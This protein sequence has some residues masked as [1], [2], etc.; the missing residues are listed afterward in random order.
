MVEII[1][2]SIPLRIPLEENCP[3]LLAQ[4]P[5]QLR[6]KRFL[7]QVADPDQKWAMVKPILEMAAS[8]E[9]RFDRTKFVAF[10]EASIPFRYKDEIL[11][12]IQDRFFPNTVAILG[13]EHVLF[14]QY[15]QLLSE[16]R[17]LNEEAYELVFK[18]RT[19][20]EEDQPVNWCLIAVK[21]DTGRLRLYV[22]A[23]THP[24]FGEEFL[25]QPHDLYRG[26]HLYLFRSSLSPL[27][28]MVLICLDYIYRDRHGSN[29][30]AIIRKAN[31]LFYK[32]RQQ[33][34]LLI[35]IQCNPKP[36]H[37]VFLDTIIGFY[38]EHLIFT[39][40]VKYGA[41]LF[42]NSSGET[43]IEGVTS[44]TFGYSSVIVHKERRLPSTAVAEYSTDDLSGGP[45]AR[46]RFGRET[47]LYL[48]ELSL[49][50]SRDPRTTRI[51]VKILSI[52]CWE[53]G[54]WRPLEGEEIILGIK[55][56]HEMKP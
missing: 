20:V 38:G 34:D 27:N 22:E 7:Y 16:Y 35:V 36:E 48:V 31:E 54:K 32:E 42:L 21:D 1:E 52:W 29:A 23:K 51:P 11:Q 5:N 15:W 47:R 49:F 2:K 33:L 50:H 8:R 45:V 44:G 18:E 26:R 39:P 25:D 28:F 43:T 37:K 55:A 19:G 14:R 53:E 3:I 13:F 9:G 4:L 41:T 40:G 30:I 46:L 17:A 10:P 56:P 6:H 12:F 24:F